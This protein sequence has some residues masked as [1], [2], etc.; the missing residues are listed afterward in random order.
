MARLVCLALIRH[1]GGPQQAQDGGCGCPPLRR[2]HSIPPYRV[3]CALLAACAGA[4]VPVTAEFDADQYE[5]YHFTKAALGANPRGGPHT[6]FV[7][8]D[9]QKFAIGTLDASRSSE[10]HP[11]VWP[12][13][14][15]S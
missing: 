7:E 3:L 4:K 15:R 6:L 9:G 11:A 1:G 2:H 5:T 8:K 10:V 14:I 13:C 12:P